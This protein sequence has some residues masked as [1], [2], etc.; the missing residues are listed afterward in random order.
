MKS[1]FAKALLSISIG[2]GALSAFARP[3]DGE[4]PLY[5]VGPADIQCVVNAAMRRGVPANVLLA[6]ASIEGGKNGQLVRNKNG[7]DDVGHFQINTIHFSEGGVFSHVRQTDAAWRGCYNADLAAQF[8][9]RRLDAPG[10]DDYWTRVASYHSAT[11]KYNAI[12][13]AKLIP[14]AARWGR[15]L[16][17]NYTTTVSYN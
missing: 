12:Y 5:R 13:R 2:T 10:S 8:L 11:P 14:L 9:R 16:Q 1:G 7:S 3:A 17:A 15:W 6:L 4:D